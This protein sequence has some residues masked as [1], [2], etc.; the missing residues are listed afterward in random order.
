MKD[1]MRVLSVLVISIFV[2]TAF[3]TAVVGLP[4][5][6]EA[7]IDPICGHIAPSISV[8]HNT[9]INES[10]AV[11]TFFIN[12]MREESDL[13][14][15]L[16][17]PNGTRINTTV[18]SS[19]VDHW[20]DE[21][22]EYY[23]VYNPQKGVWSFEIRALDVPADGEDYCLLIDQTYKNATLYD[24]EGNITDN[25]DGGGLYCG[26][27]NSSTSVMHN[28]TIGAN[29]SAAYFLLTWAN[30]DSDLELVMHLPNGTRI[31]PT[32]SSS[33]VDHGKDGTYEYY[34]IYNPQ[35]GVWSF[36][37][38]ALDVPADGEDYCLLIDQTYKNATLYDMEST[39]L[40]M[41]MEGGGLYRGHIN[42]S[43][44][45]MHNTT[46]DSNISAAQFL[47]AWTKA[48]SDLD[49]VVYSPD[50]T[51]I[52]PLPD[53]SIIH[54]EEETIEYY[55]VQDPL[56]GN[57]T[58]KITSKDVPRDGED[59][60]IIIDL[61]DKRDRDRNGEVDR[62]NASFSGIYYDYGT[63]VDRDELYDYITVGVGI[64]VVDKGFYSVA[65]KLC[66][67]NGSELTQ[68]FN[69]TYLDVGTQTVLL[70]LHGMR[71]PGP[72]CLKNLS[73]CGEAGERLDYSAEA[74]TINA[75]DNLDLGPQLAE[76]T[77][78]YT[79]YGMDVDSDGLY[80][81]LTVDVCIDVYKPK[82]YGLMGYLYD[83]NGTEVVWSI[84]YGNLDVGT[85]TI[86]MDFD[87]KTI[88]EHGVNG[89][90][91]LKYIILFSGSSDTNLTLCDV[92]LD[93]YTTSAYN[94]LDFVD[95][96]NSENEV[97]ISRVGLG[98]IRLIV[99]FKDTIPVFAGR[100]SYDLVGI[101]VPQRPN[102]FTITASEVKNLKLGLKKIQDNTTRIWVT[103][104]IVAPEGKATA[105]SDLPSPG[106]YHVKI[107]GDAAEGASE[108]DMKLTAVKKIKASRDFSLSIDISG[109]PAGKYTITA[110][111]DTGC[112]TDL[113]L[114][115][116]PLA[117]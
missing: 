94:S 2:L 82:N 19:S 13:V 59:Y 64:N 52:E 54:G 28:T 111:V 62:G 3:C 26:H 81:Y 38:R 46:I 10:V 108:V 8:V 86:H 32:L 74:Y 21:T 106:N 92:A 110:R 23:T 56:E 29:I 112:F 60:C 27:I 76:L 42:S 31:N 35:E 1:L 99:S 17:T 78:N 48:D 61:I 12:W 49:L 7:P 109:F 107:F 67:L 44:T 115:G 66:D 105:Q 89:P 11:A 114:D 117:P 75:Y 6:D 51:K 9:T 15:T 73:L 65:G 18:R 77:G 113:T 97:T 72:Y 91:H 50:G 80:D 20:K 39:D 25:T 85:H 68:A 4:A 88:E 104:T 100:Y 95:P 43:A 45:L 34:T 90:Y 116:L 30:A 93:A 83:T 57:W 55:I 53:F 101:N 14:L 22:Y 24:M 79:D 96:V 103:Q 102:N 84:G 58:A 69:D 5:E 87:G 16:V 63:D 40:G 36:E 71:S 98:E 47:I 70:I 41:D 33:S 37:I